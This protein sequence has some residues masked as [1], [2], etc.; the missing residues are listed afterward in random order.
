MPKITFREFS[1]R[2]PKYED[3]N[4]PE[5]NATVADN[6]D[7]RTASI[8]PLKA[9]GLVGT[10]STNNT[11]AIHR[12]R[13]NKWVYFDR[14]TDIVDSVVGDDPYNRLF[15]VDHNSPIR[16][17][18]TNY[19]SN[20]TTNGSVL[21]G[22][23]APGSP[24]TV[25]VQG[26]PEEGAT[27]ESRA[28]VTTLVN[29]FGEEGPPS[30]PSPVVDVGPNQT[31]QVNLPNT[32][33]LTSGYD[34][35]LV[36]IYRS[37]GGPYLFVS[38][39]ESSQSSF[40]DTVSNVGLGEPMP[41][42]DWE[43]PPA[44]IS[45]LVSVTG[46]F[47]GAW[48]GNQV[49]FSEFGLPHAWPQQYR[50]SVEWDI[51][52]CGTAGNSVVVCTKGSPY[53]AQGAVPE[54]MQLQKIESDQSCVSRESIVSMRGGVV[55]ASPE[56]LMRVS[57][58]GAELITQQVFTEE[59]WQELYP[60]NMRGLLWE[61]L[62]VCLY[63]G[64]AFGI[65]PDNPSE[66]IVNLTFINNQYTASF[67]DLSVGDLYVA[68]GNQI[69]KWDSG[70]EASFTWKS[71]RAQLPAP[72]VIKYVQVTADFYPITVEVENGD[73]DSTSIDVQS[74]DPV[75]VPA[76]GLSRSYYFSVSGTGRVVSMSAST[77]MQAM[78]LM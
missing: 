64:G 16:A 8:K 22:V 44:V 78:R 45:G 70:D 6:T 73:G 47:L 58:N 11:Q 31:V 19:I 46:G 15:Y 4:L 75:K 35:S 76:L 40:N 39:V 9:P 48:R 59:Q 26:S 21:L 2:I 24:T 23:P 74:E 72:D 37:S 28:Y 65:N 1:G 71:K 34:I 57:P 41:S 51:V 12:T 68:K 36:N 55:Y 25:T 66:G 67:N 62:Y 50:Q 17:V 77:T 20:G 52:G 13:S 14:P 27:L 32:A 42:V 30:D 38:A 56:G 49:L 53:I 69:F 54:A 5:K 10:S 3:R 33:G 61:R 60:S 43:K 63:P 29:G 7:L 18:R